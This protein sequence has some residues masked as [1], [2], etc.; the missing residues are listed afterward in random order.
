[1]SLLLRAQNALIF[2]L[3]PNTDSKRWKNTALLREGFL[4]CGE[5]SDAILFLMEDMIPYPE[6]ARWQYFD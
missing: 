2:P 6:T 1:M 4:R 3:A 5:F